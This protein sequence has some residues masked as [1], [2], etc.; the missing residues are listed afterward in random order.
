MRFL[1]IFI[2]GLCTSYLRLAFDL[3]VS[4]ADHCHIITLILNDPHI[5]TILYMEIFTIFICGNSYMVKIF[6]IFKIY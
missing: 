1:F 2:D 5:F 6:Y 4:L 3:S